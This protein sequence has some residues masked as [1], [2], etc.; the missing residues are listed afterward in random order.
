MSR[1]RFFTPSEVSSHNTADDLWVSLLGRVLD[2]SPLAQRHKGDALLLPLLESAGKDI[3]SWFDPDT[4]D[5]RCFI[6]PL[7]QCRRYYTPRGRFLH[8]P[9]P[10]PRSDWACEL[11]PPWW[12]DPSYCIGLLSHKTRWIRVINTL[13]AQEQ[14]LEVCSEETMEEVLARYLTYNSHAHSY[15]WKHA[16]VALNMSLTLEENGLRDDDPELD[17]LR[18][19]HDLF[20][21]G[22]LLHFNDDLTEA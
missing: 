12:R 5:V 3:S 4:K 1:S 20:S 18:L 10:G 17:D 13:T 9:P 2:L 14:R 22:L 21:P 6:D 11:S 19:D 15:T 8:V 16:G 7:T